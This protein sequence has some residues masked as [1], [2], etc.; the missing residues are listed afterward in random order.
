M[1]K[2]KTKVSGCFRTKE[3]ANSFMKIMS[4]LGTAKKHKISPIIALKKALLGEGNFI[5]S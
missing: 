1:I 5:F 4:Y 2:V 3:G